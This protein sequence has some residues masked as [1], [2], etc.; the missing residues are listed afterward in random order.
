MLE[1]SK[2]NMVDDGKSCD[3]RSVSLE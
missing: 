2:D 1:V 3:E